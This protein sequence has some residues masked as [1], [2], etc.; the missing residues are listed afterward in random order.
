[1]TD[2][3]KFRKQDVSP[4]AKVDEHPP[5]IEE[6]TPLKPLEIAPSDAPAPA[7]AAA[8]PVAETSEVAPASAP[9]ITAAA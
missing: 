5:V 8:G 7:A 6:P 9:V 3:F 1:M 2:F 4:P